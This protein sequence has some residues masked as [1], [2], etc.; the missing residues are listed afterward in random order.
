[1]PKPRTHPIWRLSRK[2]F[3]KLAQ[4]HNSIRS[5]LVAIGLTPAGHRYTTVKARMKEEGIDYDAFKKRMEETKPRKQG[6]DLRLVMVKDSTYPRS[7]LK[8]RLIREG[9]MEYLCQICG[10]GPEW[11]G[12]ELV[13]VLDH[14]NGVNND[15]RKK[16]LRF[17]C[18]NCNSQT[19][20]F[21]GRNHKKRGRTRSQC[22]VC[23]GPKTRQASS[24]WTCSKKRQRRVPRPNPAEL[25][26]LV[27][28]YG[29]SEVG[30][31]HGVTET[32]VRNWM[33]Q[34]NGD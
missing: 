32:T 12:H 13:L 6:T 28:K 23:K 3:K 24:C 22:P 11:K 18:P 9:V 16:N 7:K 30:R 15:H 4:D 1:M 14:I 19:P 2:E 26:Q 10:Q 27:Q 20:T 17:L 31:R 29:R 8:P 21:C 25:R 34:I 5:M 33:K